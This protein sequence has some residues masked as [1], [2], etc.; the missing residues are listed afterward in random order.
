MW[1]H[2][3]RS[4]AL[5]ILVGI[6]IVITALPVLPNLPPPHPHPLP[7]SLTK[8]TDP[9]NS[10]DYFDQVK[11]VPVGYLVWSQF[12]ITVSIQ[13]LTPEEAANPFLAKRAKE[14]IS[15]VSQAVQEWTPYLPLKVVSEAAGVDITVRRSPPPLRLESPAL[16]PA[17]TLREQRP[18]L[19]L[20]RARSAE[21]RFEF[22]AK[23]EL[24][25]RNQEPGVRGE[26]SGTRGHGD[27][28]DSSIQNSKFKIQN[29]ELSP[30][31]PIPYP[32]T[33]LS[34]RFTIH[35]RPDQAPSYLQA[36]ARHELGHALGIWGHSPLET[37]VMYFSQVR[38]PP[39]ISPRDINTLKK[40]YQQPTRL[41]WRCPTKEC[42]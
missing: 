22:Y 14:W 36:A 37:D 21:T 11:R 27:A 7:P 13:P 41:G 25:V 8:W 10:G 4:L 39:P 3:R 20:S 31:S 9:Q 12:P 29:S 38:N 16:E 6:M 28:G 23:Q 35:L 19:S 15:A 5:G 24:G 32:A 42:G 33:L 30:P 17:G 40:V 26:D 1:Y 34:Q 18:G 2:I